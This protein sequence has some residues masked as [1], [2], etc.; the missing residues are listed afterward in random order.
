[1]RGGTQAFEAKEVV[2][3]AAR[4]EDFIIDQDPF[5]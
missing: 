4:R 2:Q 5:G 1:M 3:A